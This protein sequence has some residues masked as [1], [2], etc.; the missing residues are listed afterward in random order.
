M[1]LPDRI[2]A[3][4][5]AAA[6]FPWLGEL[7]E[8]SIESWI[9]L[10]LGRL[11]HDDEPTAYGHHH[12]FARPLSPILH[13]VSGNTPHAALQS[14]IRGIIVGAKN[15][16][17]L[18]LEG[19]PE[20]G[21][22]SGRLPVALRPE[23][24]DNLKPMWVEEAEAIVVFGTDETVQQFSQ[25]LL[26]TQRLLAHGHK[27]SFGL[28]WEPFDREIVEGAA[29]DAFAFDQLGCLSPQLFY[30]AGDSAGFAAL[31]AAG[32]SELCRNNP[33]T[34]VRG[35]EIAAA[36]RACRE[37]WKFRAATESG[38]L[39]WESPGTLD[40]VVIHDPDPCLV[41]NPLHRTVFIKP[42]PSDPGL[43]L[44]PVRRH[45]STVGLHPVNLEA[46]E[47]AIH[48]GAQRI[49]K[50]GQM[51]NPPLSWHHDGWPALASLIRYVDVEGLGGN[52]G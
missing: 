17:K 6:E 16:M 26:P 32:L 48:L 9:E 14:L 23:L 5:F 24:A 49:C 12:C 35:Y 30:V 45:I 31:L 22:F 19:L 21:E 34:T 37:E 3:V 29:R 41:A 11:L 1:K 4:V 20:A 33:M 10:E 51:Q 25:L 52:S 13:V 44:A 47:L 2:E 38:V 46:V 36:L 50:I 18:P 28:V 39:V 27:I 8:E 7:T 42:M 43:V 15:W 40:W